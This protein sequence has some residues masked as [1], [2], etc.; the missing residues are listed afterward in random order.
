MFTG[1]FESVKKYFSFL[2]HLLHGTLTNIFFYFI[3]TSKVAPQKFG[4]NVQ[5]GDFLLLNLLLLFFFIEEEEEEEIDY[6]GGEN[7]RVNCE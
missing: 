5:K 2:N 4:K 3:S 1:I 6:F 7:L